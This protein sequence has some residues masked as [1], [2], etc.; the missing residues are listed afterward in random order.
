M[1]AL[2]FSFSSPIERQLDPTSSASS[3]NSAN[4]A[5]LSTPEISTPLPNPNKPNHIH[6]NKSRP[7]PACNYPPKAHNGCSYPQEQNPWQKTSK[8]PARITLPGLFYPEN[9]QTCA[10]KH[11][12]MHQITTN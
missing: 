6:P 3:A 8:I 7:A 12:K 2:F 1:P 10:Q 5:A 9:A 4:P 11:I